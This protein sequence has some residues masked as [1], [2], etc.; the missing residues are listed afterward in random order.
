[1]EGQNRAVARTGNYS[2]KTT[3]QTS[4]FC[5]LNYLFIFAEVLIGMC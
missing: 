2:P 3:L 5:E 4:R 1:M